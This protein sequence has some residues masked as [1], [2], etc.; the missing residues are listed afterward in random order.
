M[1][2]AK[3]RPW[4]GPMTTLRV[5]RPDGSVTET[6]RYHDGRIITTRI[7]SDTKVVARL[8]IDV[9]HSGTVT[10]TDETRDGEAE[11]VTPNSIESRVNPYGTEIEQLEYTGLL[12]VSNTFDDDG[13]LRSVSMRG[14]WGEQDL[15]LWTDGARR[16]TW[17]NPL[18]HGA[19]NWDAGG[20]LDHYQVTFSDDTRYRWD[21]VNALGRETILSWD[22]RTTVCENL[23]P[24]RFVRLVHDEPRP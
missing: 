16:M 12:S 3:H 10:V 14:E 2:G 18:Q 24:L 9:H 13:E 1:N 22:G 11:P 15:E 23:E 7:G 19:A 21:L 4:L 6:V 17:G 20:S 5:D 8:V